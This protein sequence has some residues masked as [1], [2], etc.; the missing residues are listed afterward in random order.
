MSFI[1][2]RWSVRTTRSRLRRGGRGRTTRGAYESKAR[3]TCRVRAAIRTARP[4]ARLNRR[5]SSPPPALRKR[6]GSRTG[7]DDLHGAVLGEGGDIRLE[8]ILRRR[9]ATGYRCRHAHAR[10]ESNCNKEDEQAAHYFVGRRGT[11]KSSPAVALPQALARRRVIPSRRGRQ[12]A[13][14]GV[15]RGRWIA[16]RASLKLVAARQG[17]SHGRHAQVAGGAPSSP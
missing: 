8:F 13:S 1:T 17:G 15:P 12:Q 2:R 9:I 7:R 4:K 3:T 5:A 6:S 11:A 16:D 14:P 10:E